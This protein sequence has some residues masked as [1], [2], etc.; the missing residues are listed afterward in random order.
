MFYR[1][2]ACKKITCSLFSLVTDLRRNTHTHTHTHTHTYTLTHTLTRTHSHIHTHTH[3][4]YILT[5]THNTYS[6]SHT[7]HTHTHTHTHTLTIHTHTHTIHTHTHSH[8]LHFAVATVHFNSQNALLCCFTYCKLQTSVCFSSTQVSV[9]FS[10]ATFES[11]KM[12]RF[13]L[14]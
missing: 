9:V 11:Q 12:F 5:H 2:G 7:I 1:I 14:T 4:Q 13:W 10:L 3:T 6:H 8:A